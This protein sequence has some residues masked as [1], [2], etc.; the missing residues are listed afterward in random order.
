MKRSELILPV[1]FDRYINE[2][3]DV[4]LPEALEISLHELENAALPSWKSIG[5]KVYAPGKWTIRDILQHIID[6]ER[7]FSYRA[8]SFARGEATVQPFDEDGYAA[9]AGA[10]NRDWDAIMEEAICVRKS[11]ISLFN[12]FTP[13][14]L[15]KMGM[16]FKGEY[17]VHAIGFILAGH[18]R[19]HF[20]VINEKYL[21]LL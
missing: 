2:T 12:S 16:G 6:T 4:T 9:N 13:E 7:V 11:T 21:P 20:S 8:L 15:S 19:W 1:Y 3:D 18:Q 14:M 17:S 5:N 10:E